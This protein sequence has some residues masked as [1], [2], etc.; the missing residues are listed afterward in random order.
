M[1]RVATLLLVFVFCLAPLLAQKGSKGDGEIHD[2]VMIRLAGDQDVKGTGINVEVNGG[3]VTLT[4]KVE[5]DKIRNKAEKLTK[6]V[7][8]VK[9]VNNQLAVGPR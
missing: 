6:K 3:V 1:K 2:Q 7:K 8:G 4:G 9:S 5:S